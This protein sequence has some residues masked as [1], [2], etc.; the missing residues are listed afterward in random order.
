VLLAER[1]FLDGALLAHLKRQRRVDVSMPLKAHM[2]ATP[3]AIPRA[4]LADRGESQP[5]RAEQSMALV[6]GVEPMGAECEGPLNACGIRCWTQK[7]KR[8]KYIVLVTTELSLSAP[9]TVRHSEE[10]P[11]I[12]HDYE[13][14]KSGGWPRKQLSSTRS[15]ESVFDVRAVVVSDRL[16]HL[17]ATTQAGARCANKT[18]QALAFEQLRT[19]RTHSIV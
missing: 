10:R 17:L 16:E 15:S 14:L 4:A 8:T 12:A 5:S 7:Q 11:E 18:R 2:R 13:Q 6:R 9:W 3:E 19:Q 1:G